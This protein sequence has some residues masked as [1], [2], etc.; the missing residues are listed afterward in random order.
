MSLYDGQSN[1]HS[2]AG[3]GAKRRRCEKRRRRERLDPTETSERKPKPYQHRTPTNE[4]AAQ[5]DN[6]IKVTA[7]GAK[8][9]ITL[10]TLQHESFFDICD[11]LRNE[12]FGD[13]TNVLI[14]HQRDIV[15]HV[16]RVMIDENLI[17]QKAIDECRKQS[18]A[19]YRSRF[20]RKSDIG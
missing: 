14:S 5:E 6:T 10:L 13:L 7:K 9:R 11:R 18:Q 3:P 17:T 2:Y 1:D 4:R 8:H 19:N 16:L 12:G 15:R 20:K